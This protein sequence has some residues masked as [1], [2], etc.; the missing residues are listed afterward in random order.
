MAR[1]LRIADEQIALL[2]LFDTMNWSNVP[3]NFWTRTSYS[4]QK[5]VFHIAA[6]LSLDDRG[7]TTFLREKMAVLRTRIPVWRGMLMSLFSKRQSAAVN[8]DLLL[9]KVW[10]INDKASWNYIPK[11]YPG[12]I[13]D[14]RPTKQYRVFNKPDLK[15][16]RLAQGGQESVVLPVY[17][18]TMLIEP[19][20][21]HLAVALRKALGEAM[22]RSRVA[23][24]TSNA[25]G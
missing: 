18:A 6:F 22:D 17:P 1:Q 24:C 9:A 2:A 19:F 21:T 16:D 25:R 3:L 15:W 5:G 8:D 11:P 20:V 12:K 10:K 23:E 13:V 4:I 14:F 7:R